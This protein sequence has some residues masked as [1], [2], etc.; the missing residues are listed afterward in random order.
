MLISEFLI[1]IA[2]IVAA[3]VILT[4]TVKRLKLLY[5][6]SCLGKIDGVH[7]EIDSYLSFF[8]PRPTRTAAA[9]VTVGDKVYSVRIFNGISA[10]HSVH[11]ASRK[12]ASVSIKTPGATKAR[13]F[14]RHVSA[15][16]MD[17]G[18]AHFARTVIMPPMQDEGCL[19]PVIIFNPAPRELTYVT[20]EKNSI[21]VAF[22]GDTVMGVRIFTRSTFANFIDRS[23]RGFYT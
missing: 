5:T 9:R 23:S 17:S 18:S 3:S 1:L 6:V 15:V 8:I 10:S 14:G 19:I 7:V 4:Y 11:F 13:I 22:T 20:P 21:K 16:K 2:T 12:F